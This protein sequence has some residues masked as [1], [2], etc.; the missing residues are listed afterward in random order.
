MRDK[1]HITPTESRIN[2]IIRL[3]NQLRM[4]YISADTEDQID[5]E[6]VKDRLHDIEATIVEIR[7]RL[8][9]LDDPH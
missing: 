9:L 8:G 6:D 7:S 5:M 2:H 1:N 4:I 3:G